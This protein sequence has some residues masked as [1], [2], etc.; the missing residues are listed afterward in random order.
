MTFLT[1]SRDTYFSRLSG[2]LTIIFWIYFFILS[3]QFHYL[4]NIYQARIHELRRYHITPLRLYWGPENVHFGKTHFW[5]P[6]SNLMIFIFLNNLNK[7]QAQLFYVLGFPLR[8]LKTA[9]KTVQRSKKAEKWPKP[10]PHFSDIAYKDKS[11]EKNPFLKKLTLR[12][13]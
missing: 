11:L 3:E 10:F 7:N 5:D 9:Q 2:R 4:C 6:N 1:S 12:F 13:I 8:Y